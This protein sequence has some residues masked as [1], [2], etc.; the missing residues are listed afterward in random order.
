M[1]R[2]SRPVREGLI[3]GFLAYLSVA[4]FY[5]LFDLLAARGPL[6]T[7]NMVGQAVFRGLRDPAVLQLPVPLDTGAIFTYN[8]LHLFVS[9][10]IGIIV[11]QLVAQAER[12]PARGRLALAVI[13]AGFGVTILAVGFLTRSIR[14][15]LPWWSIV[16]ANGLAVVLAGFYLTRRHPGIWRRLAYAT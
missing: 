6:Y 10:A 12:T 1:T 3:V 11:V 8:A 16:V 7:V 15:V 4:V 9:L 2:L 14:P 5:A 13:V